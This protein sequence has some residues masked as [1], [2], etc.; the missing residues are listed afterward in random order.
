MHSVSAT[1]LT[2]TRNH[3]LRSI[4]S[5]T[6]D[7]F[8]QERQWELAMQERGRQ[9]YLRN[10]NSMKE[11]ESEG[12]TSYGLTLI[13]SA[14]AV[15]EEGIRA[16]IADATSGKRGRMA[17][18]A[19]HL[20]GMDTGTVAF[21]TLRKM[22]DNLSRDMPLQSFA[23]TV[24]N[25]IMFEAKLKLLKEG[26]T[27][28]WEM[29]KYYLKHS[30]GRKYKATVLGYALG[31][32]QHVT[33]EPWPLNERIQ[34][35]TRL[36]EIVC[37][38]TGLFTIKQD[39]A[40]K[41][42]QGFYRVHATEKV[43]EWVT[44]HMAYSE[45]MNPDYY[46]TLIP[47]K[48]WTTIDNGGYWFQ[49]PQIITPL[50]K[51]RDKDYL[52]ALDRLIQSG[53]LEEVQN[54]VNVLQATPWAINTPVLEVAQAL[55]EAGGDRAG[56]PPRDSRHLPLCPV[57]GAD[58]TETAS[59]LIRHECLDTCDPETFITW[60]KAAKAVR[61]INAMETGKRIGV[62]KTLK[63]ASTMSRHERFYYPYQLDFRGRIY[64]I[65]SYLTPQG[66]D[67]A[68][69]LLRFAE[70]KPLMNMQAVK[71]LA[72]HVANCFGNDKVS[73][74]DRYSWTVRHQEQILA[75]AS[76]PLGET[77]WMEADE[78]FCFLAA[79]MEWAGYVT[80][81]LA[82][83]SSLPIAM[84]G[85]CNGLQIFSLMLR[86]EVGGAAV[87]LVPM[88]T[89]QDIYGI[90]AE[91]VKARLEE[92]AANPALDRDIVSASGKLTINRYRDAQILKELPINRKT[93][94]RQVMVLP[95]GGTMQ[96]CIEYTRVWMKDAATWPDNAELGRLS[97]VL[98]GYIW[99]AIGDTVIKARE[100]MDYLQGV[101]RAVS[102]LNR[103]LYWE[104]PCGLP[105]KQGYRKYDTERIETLIGDKVVRLLSPKNETGYNKIKQAN[106]ISP[107]FI[108]SLDA[109][110][111]MYTVVTCAEGGIHS[112]AMIHDSYGTHA[113]D[114]PQLARTLRE[115]FVDMFGGD[116]DLL[117]EF[118]RRIL[119]R[120][121]ELSPA[122]LPPRPGFGS[123]DVSAV[124]QSLFF[125]A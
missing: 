26:D 110:A 48:P 112:F 105:V 101:A 30:Q 50:M 10:V 15:V 99:E 36:I 61:N 28:R 78:P 56:L 83:R 68:K 88:T 51:T 34:L 94:K 64:T 106:S 60:K 63:I 13:K 74:D 115:V 21:L 6:D 113:A 86:D 108:H 27:P 84:D 37:E 2:R 125:F 11:K 122:D 55:W 67:L 89:P 116:H 41:N 70:A 29:T 92:D 31:K 120:N 38:T 81:G 17:V 100:A 76:D 93:T 90:V 23:T 98:A 117:A 53:H 104:T 54:A 4:D 65:P 111:L 85:T 75:C 19:K 109:A 24:A 46:P 47:P 49:P 45:L 1:H 87:N 96:S 42:R 44:Q 20:K 57:C 73:L 119:E 40:R 107:N 58:I 3:I 59:A 43:T 95:Y 124:R 33:F 91:K 79:C 5:I 14:I 25:E 52:R 118:E 72:I 121:P 12:S 7:T 102:R 66:T 18:A 71:W 114:A 9:R 103:P 62:A 22:I 82:F 16:Y 35:G 32:S 69:G 97:L 123:L 39:P 80:E 77:W 8:E